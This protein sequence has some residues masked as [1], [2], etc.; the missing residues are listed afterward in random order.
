MQNGWLQSGNTLYVQYDQHIG[1]NAVVVLE[2]AHK[3]LQMLLNPKIKGIAQRVEKKHQPKI[4][5]MQRAQQDLHRWIQFVQALPLKNPPAAG[6][7]SA[8]DLVWLSGGDWKKR[9]GDTPV[10]TRYSRF[11]EM[12]PQGGV[13]LYAHMDN[14]RDAVTLDMG[15]QIVKT[16]LSGVWDPDLEQFEREYKK[17]NASNPAA[18]IASVLLQLM[19]SVG[20]Q[21]VPYHL[22]LVKS[23]APLVQN[24]L[25]SLQIQPMGNRAYYELPLLRTSKAKKTTDNSANKVQLYQWEKNHRQ[26]LELMGKTDWG[27]IEASLAFAQKLLIQYANELGS[28]GIPASWTKQALDANLGCAKQVSAV[29]KKTK[30]TPL[31]KEVV[32]TSASQMVENGVGFALYVQNKEGKAGFWNGTRLSA[33]PSNVMVFDSVVQAKAYA[34]RKFPYFSAA[35]VKMQV[36]PESIETMLGQMDTSALSQVLTRKEME[37]LD[38][39]VEQHQE[40]KKQQQRQLDQQR[41]SAYCQLYESQ[42]KALGVDVDA[43]KQKVQQSTQEQDLSVQN[44][45][46]EQEQSPKKGARRRVLRV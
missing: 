35:V 45:L 24:H 3:I 34:A 33:A 30:Y 44:A 8:Q 16:F 7:P 15:E 20:G 32:F 37:H 12:M 19:N 42:L 17:N 43:L 38:E 2:N 36:Q 13:H 41:M 29:Y 39:Q 4:E 14:Q 46:P 25:K 5:Q 22:A 40:Q 23:A 1:A 9:M 18:G 21:K 10:Q 27:N 26:W 6:V 31:P 11:V 28:I